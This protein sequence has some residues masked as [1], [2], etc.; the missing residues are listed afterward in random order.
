MKFEKGYFKD[1][2]I[3]NYRDY[4]QKKY[5]VLCEDLIALGILSGHTI[6]DFGCAT[7]ALIKE[8]RDRGHQLICGTD[9]SWWA[10]KEGRNLYG[11][12]KYT[13]QHLNYSLLEFNADWLLALD[14][15]EH[16]DTDELEYILRTMS[17][18]NLVVRVPIS[19]KEGEPFVLD[20]SRN[21]QTHIQCHT[22]AWWISML[23]QRFTF[24]SSIHGEAIYDSEGVFAG[25]FQCEM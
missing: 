19:A 2:K 8:F 7:G 21:D 22:R 12:D 1:S 17:C 20:V 11:F 14:V 13:L 25:V 24:V 6:V 10:I 3:S 9:V 18:N 5:G 23:C 15:L 16:I 4:T